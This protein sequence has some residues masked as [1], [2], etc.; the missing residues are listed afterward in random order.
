[1][2]LGVIA[3]LTLGGAP[4]GLADAELITWAPK[5]GEVSSLLP[6]FSRAGEGS[7]MLSPAAWRESAH[8]IV[9]FDVT[10]PESATAVGIDA[11]QGLALS[12]RGPVSVA[13]HS[14]SDLKAFEAACRARLDRY[15]PVSKVESAG[16]TT[17][18]SRDGLNRVQGAVVLKGKEACAVHASGQTVEKQ[19]PD[20]V[21]AL[22]GKPLTGAWVK[23]AA[24][25]PAAQYFLRPEP[26][27]GQAS[28]FTGWATAALSARGDALSVDLKAKGLPLATLDGPGPSP[29]GALSVPGVMV[30]R[31]RLSKGQLPALVDQV[32]ASM[33]G[34]AALRSAGQKLA[35]ALTGN[36]ALV[37]SRV[38]V[39]SGLRTPTARFFAAR[40][41]VV[42]ETSDA[43]VASE[44]VAGLEA[45]ALTFREG[46]LTT[47]TRGP[48]VWL[49]NDADSKD[50]VLPALATASGP[51]KHGA[52]FDVDP[53]ALA[54][55][56]AA[57]PLLEVVQ[58][59]ELSP[60]LVAATEL[61]PLLGL[62]Q[63]VRGWLDPNAGGQRGQLTWAL[64]PK[65][66][67]AGD[68]GTP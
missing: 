12:T 47:G 26:P 14:V 31:L 11:S 39:T 10:R 65:V 20:V 58:S 57:V 22:T 59:P 19:L 17:L 66:P 29:F 53:Q 35:P 42:A 41:T 27:R 63:R 16:V 28:R 5:L 15:G 37:F 34:A 1:M 60:L 49:S 51:Q 45:K 64:A 2:I 33:P 54:R 50:V 23:A 56:L 38:K 6:F 68:G 9:A 52:E 43:A 30:L 62:T 8:P 36:V 55:A 7:V 44:V 13:C 3:A 67:P 61:G 4:R 25:L 32:L 21:K 46:T 40:F 48:V 24:E 18:L